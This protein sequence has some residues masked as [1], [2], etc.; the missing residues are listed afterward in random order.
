FTYKR[1]IKMHKTV[2]ITLIILAINGICITK[3]SILPRN[4][5]AINAPNPPADIATLDLF[6]VQLSGVFIR[7]TVSVSS[8]L[9]TGKGKNQYR[10]GNKV[11][12]KDGLISK[13]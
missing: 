4:K 9:Y 3:S 12:H 2:K 13:I 6:I 5:I 7:S 11:F 10:N 8:T 1:I